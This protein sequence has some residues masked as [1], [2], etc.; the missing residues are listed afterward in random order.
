MVSQR[1]GTHAFWDK[2]TVPGQLPVEVAAMFEGDAAGGIERIFVA[3]LL[4]RE[5][6]GG[7]AVLPQLVE[8]GVQDPRQADKHEAG[9]RGHPAENDL[10]LRSSAQSV[11]DQDQ[12]QA[13]DYEHG[14]V[15]GVEGRDLDERKDDPV[16]GPRFLAIED[17]QNLP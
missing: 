3:T 15:L 5:G 10:S 9:L 4:E 12:I 6:Q 16:P 7:A 1:F 11:N 17:A 2:V 13:A 14:Q 8:H